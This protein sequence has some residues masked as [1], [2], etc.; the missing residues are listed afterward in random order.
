MFGT[1]KKLIMRIKPEN[2]KNMGKYMQ[3]KSK[4]TQE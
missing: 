4:Q 2:I 3:G 1:L